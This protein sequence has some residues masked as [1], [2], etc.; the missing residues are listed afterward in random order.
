[1]CTTE[2]RLELMSTLDFQHSL[3]IKNIS[4]CC[5]LSFITPDRI[6]ISDKNNLVMINSASAIQHRR[7]DHSRHTGSHT[8]TNNNDLIY[9]DNN[10]NINKLSR[11]LKTKTLFIE[12]SE[13]SWKPRCVCCSAYNRDLLVGMYKTNP[14]KGQVSRYN[15][16]GLL[17]QT[18]PQQEGGQDIYKEPTYIV[19]NNNRNIIVSDYTWPYGAV[20]VT[21][22]EGTYLFSY[23]GHP[24][25]SVLYPRGICTDGLSNILVCD[26]GTNTV[27]VIDKN[28]YFLVKVSEGIPLPYS[29]CYDF[30]THLLWIGLKPG[31]KWKET[32]FIYKHLTQTSSLSEKKYII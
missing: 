11:D 27:H 18:I 26:I 12:M 30:N 24:P 2:P 19:E 31:Y 5:H 17:I 23:T 28:G 29:I 16:A 1:M 7:K 9:I 6:W 15:D 3:P 4:G 32:I 8:V 25:G 14:R 13:S 20:I 10:Y 21:N 22:H